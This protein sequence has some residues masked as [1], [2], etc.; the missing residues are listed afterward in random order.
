[1]TPSC[2]W[3]DSFIY[4]TWLFHM[5]DLTLSY[6]QPRRR[7]LL[8]ATWFLHKCN[9]TPIHAWYDSLSIWLLHMCDMTP[10]E[11]QHDSF[12]CTNPWEC[13]LCVP[14]LLSMSHVAHEWVMVD[15]NE[16][17][18]LIYM[19]QVMVHVHEC[20]LCVTYHIYCTPLT[21]IFHMCN[22]TPSYLWRNSFNLTCHLHKFKMYLHICD[23][24]PLYVCE[25]WLLH[26]C[27]PVTGAHYELYDRRSPASMKESCHIGFRVPPYRALLQ[28]CRALLRDT[29]KRT[30]THGNEDEFSEDI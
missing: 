4:V 21:C 11:V 22:M 15:V 16:S 24:T 13:R 26:M 19:S 9:M 12:I 20:R 6:V 29:P 14:Y 30:H 8:P 7:C 27:H 23:M 2:A 3:H 28:I 5:C 18:W 25:T 17:C 1:M 10:S